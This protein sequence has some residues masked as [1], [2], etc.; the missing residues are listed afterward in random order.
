MAT[1][2]NVFSTIA[3][4]LEHFLL[5][6]KAFALDGQSFDLVLLRENQHGSQLR[7]DLFVSARPLDNQSQLAV[8]GEILAALAQVSGG[9]A[10]TQISGLWVLRSDSAYVAAMH[11]RATT[12][13]PADPL[14]CLMVEQEDGQPVNGWLY[15][16]FLLER[17]RAGAEVRLQCSDGTDQRSWHV[18][19]SHLDANFQLHAR[20]LAPP[21]PGTRLPAWVTYDPARTSADDANFRISLAHVQQVYVE[22]DFAPRWESHP[23]GTAPASV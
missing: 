7:Y 3:R 10:A 4:G 19:L 1:S 23:F 21:L 2:P 14:R 18:R 20:L 15:R 17:L 22:A 11:Q 8:M 13:T 12:Y 5:G 16:S 6:R 9:E